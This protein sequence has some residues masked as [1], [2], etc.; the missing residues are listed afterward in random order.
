MS[1]ITQDRLKSLLS[2]DSETGVFTWRINV[3]NRLK[4]TVAGSVRANGYLVIKISGR[5]YRAHRLAWLYAYGVWP[6]EQIDHRNGDR[7]DNRVNN[8]REATHQE[9]QMNQK[10][11]ADNTSGFRGVNWHTRAKKWVAQIQKGGRS[12]Y[13]G[14]FPTPEAASA[15]YEAKATQLFGEFKRD[16]PPGA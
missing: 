9:N 6:K 4:G 15:A 5:N 8:L 7:K 11:H 14:S 3:S 16:L 12:R 10:F 1:T 13:L 2:Y